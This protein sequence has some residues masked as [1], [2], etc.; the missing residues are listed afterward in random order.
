MLDLPVARLVP[1][2]PLGRTPKVQ[3]KNNAEKAPSEASARASTPPSRRQVVL[4]AKG[5]LRIN[6]RPWSQVFVDGKLIGNTPQM[7]IELE[8]GHH[9]ITL[10]NAEFHIQKSLD[11]EIPAGET[12]V[13]I[14]DLIPNG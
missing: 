2:G 3:A 1:K 10:V 8:P 14:L 9:R 13:K 12:V 4:F 11:I 6:T 7:N 5:V